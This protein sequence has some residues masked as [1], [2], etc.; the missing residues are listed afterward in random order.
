MSCNISG[1]INGRGFSL[2]FGHFTLATNKVHQCKKKNASPDLLMLHNVVNT[3]SI[4]VCLNMDKPP[5]CSVE[6][7]D[8][9]PGPTLVNVLII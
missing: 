3:V 5:G 6:L 1:E 7:E 4:C 8:E 9:S 2:A